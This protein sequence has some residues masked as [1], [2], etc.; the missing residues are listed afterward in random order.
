MPHFQ[1]SLNSLQRAGLL[2]VVCCV[3][4]NAAAQSL[5]V[6][7]SNATTTLAHDDKTIVV[8]CYTGQTA[9]Q[10]VAG[11][12]LMGFDAVSLNAGMG[13]TANAPAGWANKGFP[14]VQ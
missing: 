5:K 14:V 1:K 2:L 12:R 3:A 4:G 6:T 8:Y 13:T 9:G 7:E 11:L 10:A